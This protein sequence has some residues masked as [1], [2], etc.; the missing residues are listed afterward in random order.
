MT[1]GLVTEFLQRQKK[2]NRSQLQRLNSEPSVQLEI[3]FF[4]FSF[5]GSKLT[6]TCWQDHFTEPAWQHYAFQSTLRGTKC[7]YTVHKSVYPL[8]TRK[9]THPFMA[10]GD[11]QSKFP[12]RV[13]PHNAPLEQERRGSYTNIHLEQA[14][15]PENVVSLERYQKHWTGHVHIS[16]GQKSCPF[17]HTNVR[18]SSTYHKESHGRSCRTF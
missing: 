15:Q 9:Q 8:A 12:S 18:S 7:C 16:F 1:S 13:L 17:C 10:R 6:R 4:P 5:N 2:H 3:F 11:S 14:H